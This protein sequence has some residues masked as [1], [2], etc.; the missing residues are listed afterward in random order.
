MRATLA[1]CLTL[2]TASAFAQDTGAADSMQAPMLPAEFP[3]GDFGWPRQALA[4]DGRVFTIYQPQ[5]DAWEDGQRLEA[6]VAVAIESTGSEGRVIGALH[7]AAA[8]ETNLDERLVVIHDVEIIEANFPTASE[9]ESTAYLETLRGLVPSA[10]REI[11]LDRVLAYVDRSAER[12]ETLALSN[13]PPPIFVSPEPAVLIVI[14]GEPIMSPVTEGNRLRFVVNTNWDLFQVGEGGNWFLRN[15]DVWLVATDWQGPWRAAGRLP[16]AFATVPTDDDNWSAVRA[17]FPGRQVE[18]GELPRVFVADQPSELIVIDGAPTMTPLAD[19]GLHW[20]SNTESDLLH[21]PRDGN[22]YFLVSGRWFRAASLEGPWSFASRELPDS[23]SQIPADH[24]LADIRYSIPGTPEAEE[25]IILASIPEKAVVERSEATVDVSYA[26][27]PEFEAIDGTDLSYAVNTAF[28]VIKVK[29]DEYYV[30]FEGVWFVGSTA[31]GPWTV[32]DAI[33]PE[34]Y[35]IPADSPVHHTT[36][37]EV[38]NSTST[39]VTFGVTA[40]YWGVYYGHGSIYFG[41]GWYWPPYHWYSPHSYYPYYYHRPYAYGA[42]AWYNPYSGTYG[43][44]GAVY[45]PYGGFGR[46]SAYNPRTGTYARAAGAWGGYSGAMVAEAYNPRT[47][48]YGRTRQS[49]NPYGSWGTSTVTRGDQWARTASIRSSEGAIAAGRGS[50]GRG[51]VVGGTED[52]RGVIVRGANDDVY[53][54]RDGSVYRRDGDSWSQH[55][56][57]DW[58]TVNSSTAAVGGSPS[59]QRRG[60]A[61]AQLDTEHGDRARWRFKGRDLSPRAFRLRS[62]DATNDAGRR[63]GGPSEV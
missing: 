50:Q 38:Y 24:E 9:A 31:T 57:R 5:I 27:D 3:V 1:L 45:G 4:P 26:G 55:D 32:A 29:D 11:S 53:V 58:R 33:P 30:N 10:T 15:G 52:R 46:A 18:P 48:G 56:G 40:G 47:G 7:I 17:S 60:P 20:V 62:S 59:S 39:T 16:D 25:A 35:S 63:G 13:D 51:L 44:G 14:D 28:D 22:Y 34:I 42:G 43:R 54:G 19:T 2:A 23:F 61:A 6:R 37:C 41:L 49:T 8:T 12:P 21:A 36:Y